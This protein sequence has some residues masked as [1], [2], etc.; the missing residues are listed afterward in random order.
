MKRKI[1][2]LGGNGTIGSAVTEALC[3]DPG[4][5]VTLLLR[6][7][8]E[9]RLPVKAAYGDAEDG[10]GLR[11]LQQRENFPVVIDLLIFTPEQA[12]ARMEIF[13]G[14]SQYVFIST[15]CVNDRRDTVRF[16]EESP[17]GNRESLY[18]QMKRAAEEVFLSAGFPVTIIRPTQTYGGNKLPLSVKG[19]SYWGICQR[20]LDGKPVIV[21]G[22][23]TSVWASTYCT[24]FAAGLAPLIGNE[25]AV[26]EIFQ[27]TTDELLTWDQMYR[28]IGE[29]LGREPRIVH[30]PT[31]VLVQ[32]GMGGG[33]RGDK[34]SSVLFD[35]GKLKQLVPDFSPKVSFRE[36]VRRY[37]RG[38]AE[39]P[40]WKTMDPA[41]DERC[42]QVC[43]AWLELTAGFAAAM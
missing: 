21:H 12:K 11:E 36:G 20:I 31:D 1:L 32:I 13:S 19:K 6:P 25:K 16:T 42:D 37:L 17:T 35:C 2:I 10:A 34:E 28:I 15:V 27:I 22:D 5:D 33:I 8:R 3:R 23:G 7:G 39:Y 18:G 29:E 30:I 26:G 24:D 41:F 43:K 40:E 9:T 14:V 38:V 4:N